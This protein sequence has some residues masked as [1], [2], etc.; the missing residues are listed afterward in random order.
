MPNA[1]PP[2]PPQKPDQPMP[3]P[4]KPEAQARIKTSPHS[5]VSN[6]PSIT[7]RSPSITKR[8]LAVPPKSRPVNTVPLMAAVSEECLEKARSMSHD[9]AMTLDP[10]AVTEYQK[11]IATGLS[12]LE[13]LLQNSRLT[14]REE[15][16]IRL[17]Y[18]TVLHEETDNMMEAET[19]L[20]KGIS[21]CDK[22]SK[23]E[24]CVG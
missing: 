6:S 21:L 4:P 18:A 20:T 13:A 22:V 15:A 1:P 17:R 9:V 7:A 11:L 16:R 12:C 19:A 8:S 23:T 2:P 24:T 3:E 14:P 5:S 10:E